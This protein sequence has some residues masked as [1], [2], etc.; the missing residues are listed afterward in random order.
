MVNPTEQRPTDDS[1]AERGFGY[2]NGRFVPLH[3]ACIP[4]LDWGFN[5]SDVVY[6]GIPFASGRIFRLQDHLDRFA[7][8]MRKWRLPPPCESQHLVRVCHDLIVRSGLRNGIVYLCTT[9]GLPPSPK[10]RDPAKFQSRLYGW[11]QELPQL[12]T[13]DQLESGLSMIISHV[14]RI[15]AAS[16][17]ATA[18]NFHWGDL[19]QA[20]LE[21]SDRGAQNAILLTNDGFVAEGVGFNLFAVIDGQLK[22]PDRD[23]L[24]GITRRTVLE[25]ASDLKIDAAVADFPAAALANSQEVFITSSAG[26]I[27]AVTTL[28]GRSVGNGKFGRL[29]RRIADEYWIRRVSE[30]WSTPVDYAALRTETITG[31]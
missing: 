2:V 22:T 13:P 9:R 25:I 19:I 26:G 30:R 16:V 27:F 14:P 3:E 11:S 15:P 20:R 10:I 23:C 4:L 7:E 12:G 21:A 28:E 31:D 29:T 17:D 5:K 18:K 8:S 24:H 6:D 1:E